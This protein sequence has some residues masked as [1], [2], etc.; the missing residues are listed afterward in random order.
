M[1]LG[2]VADVAQSA[3]SMPP[4][5]LLVWAAAFGEHD[6]SEPALKLRTARGPMRLEEF[7]EKDL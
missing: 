5:D 2:L 1:D 6:P 3:D 4:A 7:P